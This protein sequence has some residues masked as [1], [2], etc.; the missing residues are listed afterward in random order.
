MRKR[1]IIREIKKLMDK[2]DP[3]RMGSPI[4]VNVEITL[5]RYCC[6]IYNIDKYSSDIAEVKFRKRTKEERE[7]RED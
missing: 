4:N 1:E 3:T 2:V 6:Y 7:N 5:A